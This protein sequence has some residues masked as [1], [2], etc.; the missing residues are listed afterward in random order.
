[1]T[2]GRPGG[3][4]ELNAALLG[5]NPA[6][7]STSKFNRL[8]TF[9][10][11]SAS[12]AASHAV[13]ATV[14]KAGN[15]SVR[16]TQS[17]RAQAARLF[18]GVVTDLAEVPATRAAAEAHVASGSCPAVLL[19]QPDRR[20]GWEAPWGVAASDAPETITAGISATLGT[21]WARVASRG[22]PS[23]TPAGAAP[24]PTAIPA[25]LHLDERTR[26]MLRTSIASRQ[27]VMLVGPPGTGKSQLVQELLDELATDPSIAGMTSAHEANVTT[28]DESWTV[29]EL[30]GAE[31]VDDAGRI[32]F[33]PGAV[34][35][36]ITQDRWLVL[37]EVNRADMDRIF[38]GLLTWLS[39][40]SVTV[41]RLAGDPGA[42]PVR[43]GWADS[44][45]CVVDGLDLLRSEPPSG[46]PVS[47]LAG[48]EWRMLGTYNAV[49]AH[50][51]F[52]FGLALGR[53]FA[54][55]PVS[56]PSTD[57]FAAAL[58]PYL[59]AVAT[60]DR[61]AVRDQVVG[62]YAAHLAS[63]AATLGPAVF[64]GIP[65]YV[66]AGASTGASVDE[67]VAEAYLTS[68]G[69]WLA[70]LEEDELD[71][72]GDSFRRVDVLS[73]NEWRWVRAQLQA[74]R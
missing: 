15:F 52:R 1:M 33:A 55:V 25:A 61:D 49:D 32:R 22:R 71:T 35:D 57:G 18:V 69:T 6:A 73:E 59:H 72:L 24:P 11:A 43:L 38:G 60:I 5:V 36:S 10:A 26:R 4:D 8:D 17:A 53:R 58:S 67:L 16:A 2:D 68:M 62:L 39:G 70:R 64:L 48:T 51:V 23:R 46:E 3:L 28:P 66:A 56:A 34:L 29:R 21:T 42:G 31:T 12:L 45:G 41:G 63:P 19:V 74:L 9:L 50:R 65:G 14:S 30:V 40:Q 20:G 37:D 13:S 54:Q 47:F 7:P 27:A 44:P